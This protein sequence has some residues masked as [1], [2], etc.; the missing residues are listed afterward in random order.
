MHVKTIFSSSLV[1]TQ[2]SIIN[3][4]TIERFVVSK[5]FW[6]FVIISVS[7]TIVTLALTALSDRVSGVLGNPSYFFEIFMRLE[8][9]Y[10]IPRLL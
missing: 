9:S 6:V 7:L 3:P 10:L 5:Y 2:A 4:G 8:V 1:Q